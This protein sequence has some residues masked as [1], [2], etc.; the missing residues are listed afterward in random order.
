MK[1]DLNIL[2]L[3]RCGKHLVGAAHNQYLFE[4][5]L[6]EIA[7]VA[8][9]G[10]GF[11]DH[12]PNETLDE[13][14][15]RVMPDA[16]WVIDGDD[17]L[18]L[19]LREDRSYRVGTFLSDLH[20]KHSYNIDNPVGFGSLLSS[21]DYDIFFMRYPLIY[22]TRYRSD[23]IL[24][25]I[26]NR[27]FWVPW[28]VDIEK[29][30]PAEKEI[31]VAYLG[32]MGRCYP[33]RQDIWDGIYYAARGFRVLRHDAPDQ[34]NSVGTYQG[35]RKK[36]IVGKEYWNALGK[37]RIMIFDC[38]DYLYPILKFFEASA[39][40]CLIMSNAPSMGRRLGFEAGKTMVEINKENWEEVLRFHL[41]HPEAGEKI[42]EAGMEST[43]KYHNHPVRAEQMISFMCE[44]EEPE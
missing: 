39:A 28:S 14:V 32:T 24:N 33:I 30:K 15:E 43:R 5:E 7:N 41:E 21:S 4:Q 10:E 42:A 27:S 29:F 8:Y 44:W 35:L 13:T 36:F 34:P 1:T 3:E 20:G 37:S 18:H 22:G 12:A 9:A 17:K 26:K 16:D 11:P 38:S 25:S 23:I 31:D 19:K 2:C 40:G 6:G